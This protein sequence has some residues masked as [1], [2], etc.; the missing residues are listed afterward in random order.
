M[1]ERHELS[2]GGRAYRVFLHSVG[3]LPETGWPTAFVL[4][5]DQFF[6]QAVDLAHDEGSPRLL[7]GIG[8]P[9]ADHAARITRRYFELTDHAAAAAI[10]LRL[11]QETPQTGGELL[12]AGFLQWRLLPWLDEWFPLAAGRMALFGHSLAGLFVLRAFLR[13]EL[14][15]TDFLAADPSVWWNR[16]RVL[17][18]LET[19]L[20][21]FP[22][23]PTADRRRLTILTA[24][25]E[26][27]RPGQP[28]AERE[29]FGALRGG[30]NGL[31][32]GARLTDAGHRRITAVS[33]AEETHGSI[34]GPAL[35]HFFALTAAGR[36]AAGR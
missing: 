28:K 16:H 11:G 23:H 12:F 2:F 26:D 9:E 1:Q 7:V 14:P 5:A 25:R 10:P 19:F 8:L 31:A 4:D 21:S 36:T 29:G 27:G 6:E 20:D 22:D 17:A 32:F 30:P 13:R 15:I 35:E 3:E 18:E 24:G 33:L 34:V